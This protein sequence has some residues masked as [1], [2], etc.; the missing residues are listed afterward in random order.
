MLNR[1]IYAIYTTSDEFRGNIRELFDS[2]EDAMKNRF[3]YANW[4]CDTGDVYIQLYKKE[5]PF[6]PSIEWHIDSDGHL[7]EEIEW[8]KYKKNKEEK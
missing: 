4:Y 2:L 8:D 6:S 7:I 5:R 1:D 3:K